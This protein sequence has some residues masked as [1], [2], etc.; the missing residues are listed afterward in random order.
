MTRLDR[1]ALLVGSSTILQLYMNVINNNPWKPDLV[2]DT[3]VQGSSGRECLSTVHTVAICETCRLSLG[4][5]IANEPR[6][7]G[8]SNFLKRR[9]MA[10]F[11]FRLDDWKDC[12][13][14]IQA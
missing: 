6:L 13:G 2:H 10:T 12:R 4:I 14:A 8:Q 1:L 9:N 11:N 5:H 3:V 7:P